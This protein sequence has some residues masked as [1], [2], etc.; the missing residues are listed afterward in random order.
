M[1]IPFELSDRDRKVGLNY[2][3]VMTTVLLTRW[4]P[5]MNKVALTKTLQTVAGLTLGQA[6]RVTDEVL[7]GKAVAVSVPTVENAEALIHAVAMVEVEAKIATAQRT[8]T[9][10]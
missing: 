8:G 2:G 5:G 4:R 6:K 1:E 3:A 9:H 7:D 10:G